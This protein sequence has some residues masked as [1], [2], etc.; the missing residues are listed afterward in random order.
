MRRHKIQMLI[1]DQNG[2]T[3]KWNLFQFTGITW[4]V[5]INIIFLEMA[6]P[7]LF[8]NSIHSS[9]GTQS[10]RLCPNWCP[11]VTDCSDSQIYVHALQ[12]DHWETAYI[13]DIKMLVLD[14]PLLVCNIMEKVIKTYNL[15]TFINFK[16]LSHNNT[17]FKCGVNR[18][19]YHSLAAGRSSAGAGDAAGLA[20]DDFLW[21]TPRDVNN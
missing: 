11:P 16:Y 9:E 7:T 17:S 18:N 8:F 4:C 6:C 21:H 5:W 1:E 3:G 20:S 15:S 2:R 12:G 10:P 19:D 13:N 14:R